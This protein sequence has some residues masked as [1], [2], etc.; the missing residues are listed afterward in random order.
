MKQRSILLLATLA[1]VILVVIGLVVF[2]KKTV[3]APLVTQSTPGTSQKK[4]PAPSPK[5]NLDDPT[6]LQVIVNKKRPLPAGYV[7]SDLMVPEVKLRLGAGEEQMHIRR[8][9]NDALVTMFV[10]ARKDDAELVFGSGY[11]S[12][13]LQKQFYTQYVNQSGV[14]AADRFSAR[15]GYSEHQTGLAIDINS[16]TSGCH[17]ELCFKDT[18][19]GKWLAAHAHE[20]GFVIRY[21]DG[22]ESLTGYQYEPWHVRYVG[23]ELAGKI[24][25]SSRT[26]EQYF[27]LPAAAQY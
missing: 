6:S 23:T 4:A 5:P 7:P 3:K 24:K 21:P 25:Q 19:E 9:V 27:G 17:L 11:R 22:K 12:E 16:A 14:A 20:Y 18:T 15:P 10:A 1:F 2:D 8:P 13:T 26:L